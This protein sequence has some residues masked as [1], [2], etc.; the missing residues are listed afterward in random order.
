MPKALTVSDHDREAA[1]LRY[2]YPVVS[3]RAAGLS[4]GINLNT[5]NAC[6]WRC[7]YCQV[8]GLRRGAAP[9]VDLPRLEAELQAFLEEV[10][11]GDFLRQRVP[12]GSRRLNDIALSGNGEPTSARQFEEVIDI[13]GRV[14][15]ALK[16]P[17]EVKTVLITN[18]SLVHQPQVRAGLEKMRPLSG[19]V[20]FKIDSGTE[21]GMRAVNDARIGLRKVRD[22]LSIAARAC[23][24]WVQ[25]CVFALDG[26]APSEDEQRD[27]L[28]LLAE[29]L[30]AGVA[31][32]GV[33]LYGLARQSHQPEAARLSSLPARWLESYAER[34]RAL[35]LVVKVTP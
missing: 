13:I 8:P 16:V 26:A 21:A 33:L 31:I 28:A 18:G 7:V 22:N 14:R 5:N 34:I 4:V 25:T 3:R 29:R 24:T 20:W 6:N 2:V 10:L 17:W 35:G 32:Q 27:Y 9:A 23:P 15:A 19:E 1:G 12:A 11:R 30:N